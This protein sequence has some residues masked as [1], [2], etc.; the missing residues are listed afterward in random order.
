[1][2][3]Y[4]REPLT[5]ASRIGRVARVR[6]VLT[7]DSRR[8]ACRVAGGHASRTAGAGR[9]E[10]RAELAIAGSRRQILWSPEIRIGSASGRGLVQTK[11][12]SEPFSSRRA[13][14][15]VAAVYCAFVTQSTTSTQPR[16]AADG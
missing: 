10:A 8:V 2:L 7:V 3:E 16:S 15:G 13:G 9:S 11:R 5:R 4:L 6:V 1:M 14:S 12:K